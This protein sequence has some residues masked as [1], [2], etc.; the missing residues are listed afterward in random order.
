MRMKGNFGFIHEKIEIKVLILFILRRLAEPIAFN[1]LAELT[2]CDDG[3]SYFVFADCVAE[4]VK[5]EHIKLEDN[6]YSVTEKGERNGWIT[7]NSLPYSVRTKAEDSASAL[8]AAQN[9][10][11]MIR[12][13][14]SDNPEGG[15]TVKLSLSDGVG[16][17]LSLELFS[18]NERQSRDLENGF[19]K[20]AEG[21]YH[22]IIEMILG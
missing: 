6:M 11:A 7:E 12:T 1:E 20:N 8:R 5:T 17:I 13:S 4:L 16:D 14:H 18:A 9:R 3:I 10:N 2:M 15:C 19:R 21:I 22:A